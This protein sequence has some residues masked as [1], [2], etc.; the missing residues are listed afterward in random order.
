MLAA[1]DP[2]V[3]PG[4]RGGRGVI[5]SDVAVGIRGGRA[6]LTATGMSDR[7][8]T[9]SLT[10]TRGA[11]AAGWQHSPSGCCRPLTYRGRSD[12]DPEGDGHGSAGAR[13]VA[14]PIVRRLGGLPRAASC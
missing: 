14:A 2:E 13:S 7:V 1:C 12:K 8:G 11:W 5:A 4:E 10:R 6:V 9:R 3:E